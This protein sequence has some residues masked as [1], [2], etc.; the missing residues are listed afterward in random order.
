M[1][2]RVVGAVGRFCFGRLFAN[3]RQIGHA[4][5]R[6][7]AGWR[8]ARAGQCRVIYRIDENE[9]IVHVDRADHRSDVYRPRQAGPTRRAK[10]AW[11]VT[12]RPSLRQ[13]VVQP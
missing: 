13:S 3:P 8:S 5:G 9:R 7:P 4:L 6:E 11:V 2:P 12:T 10:A 1:S